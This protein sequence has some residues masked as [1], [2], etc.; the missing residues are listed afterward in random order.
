MPS[1]EIS[2][3]VVSLGTNLEVPI[4]AEFA[5]RNAKLV[6]GAERHLEAVDCGS[7]ATALYPSPIDGLSQLIAQ[8]DAIH[9]VVLASGDALFYGIGS[10]LLRNFDPASLQF[11]PNVTTVQTACARIGRP[12]QDIQFTS[13]HGRPMARLRAV[14]AAGKSLAV[15]TDPDN[16]PRLISR[17]LVA[18]GYADSRVHVCESLDSDCESIREY[19]A[20]Q[21][22]ESEIRIHPLNL[23]LIDVR[24]EGGLLPVFPGIADE[25]F[26]AGGDNMF[27]KREVR[28]AALSRLALDA[29]ETGWD[30]GAGSG[31]IAVEW[32]RW[33]PQARVFAIERDAGRRKILENN[34]G[35]FGDHGNLE[36]IAGEAPAALANLPDP[37]AIYVG[38]SGGHLSE[39]LDNCWQRLP[40]GGRLV[41]AGVTVETRAELQ[42]RRWSAAVSFCDIAISHAAPLG[43]QT[44]MR[45]QLPVLLTTAIKS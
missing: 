35:R 16:T 15:F 25:T 44:T 38:G 22:A 36:L 19:S 7:A 3:V 4:S 23:L 30:I 2:I 45:A 21:L 11:H 24:G 37:S 29:G 41:A 13:L 33:A 8:S 1:R 39:L 14:L 6:I 18:T 32:A 28:L 5:L 27:T 10:W 42:N 20:A 9:V 31:G 17:E 12:W 34:R 26:G 43:T 40:I